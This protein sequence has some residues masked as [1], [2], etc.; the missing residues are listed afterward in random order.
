MDFD[1]D[2]NWQAMLFH[3]ALPPYAAHKLLVSTQIIAIVL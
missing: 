1:C 2:G 3:A